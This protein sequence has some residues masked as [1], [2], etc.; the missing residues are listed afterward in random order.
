[1]PKP[2]KFPP[3]LSILEYAYQ[4][5]KAS[6]T[7]WFVFKFSIR[8]D[9]FQRGRSCIIPPMFTLPMALASFFITDFLIVYIQL[10]LA[11]LR[12]QVNAPGQ[13]KQLI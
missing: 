9:F 12:L 8:L 13:G 6:V 3:L 2:V 5:R 7:Y 10:P 11:E 4:K 1:M